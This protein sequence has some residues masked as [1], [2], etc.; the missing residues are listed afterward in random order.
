MCVCVLSVG[1]SWLAASRPA[2]W[3]PCWG[4]VLVVVVMGGRNVSS[5]LRW[6]RACAWVVEGS[7][8]GRLAPWWQV[9]GGTGSGLAEVCGTCLDYARRAD[10]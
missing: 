1:C 5:G 9:G 7:W 4:P 2:R 6:P 3:V 8:W 10:L